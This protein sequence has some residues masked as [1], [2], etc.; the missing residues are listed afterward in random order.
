MVRIDQISIDSELQQR[1]DHLN[2][3]TVDEYAAA[4][5]TGEQFPS[6]QLFR[7]GEGKLWLAD[8]FHRV[9][10]AN[11]AGIEELSANI[12]EGDYRAALLHA[13][14]V[15]AKHGLR[16]SQEDKR[17]AVMTLLEDK[18]WSQWSDREV[19]RVAGVDHKT[20]GKY[21]SE[22]DQKYLGNSPDKSKKVRR[23]RNGKSQV[24][25]QRQKGECLSSHNQA[26]ATLTREGEFAA[27]IIESARRMSRIDR[28]NTKTVLQKELERLEAIDK[29][30]VPDLAKSESSAKLDGTP[31]D[32]IQQAVGMF[33]WQDVIEK[34]IRPAAEAAGFSVT[35][36]E[37]G[38]RERV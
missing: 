24:F 22:F 2:E 21:R 20:V 19:A 10:A 13:I 7:D 38:V 9:E 6:V 8:G 35:T 33:N 12:E 18:E 16:R 11:K 31:W 26:D 15:N 3:T 32:Q 5:K 17:R 4:L 29:E 1:L 37:N 36:Q 25:E 27:Q 23:I 28:E 30:P 14:G 34:A